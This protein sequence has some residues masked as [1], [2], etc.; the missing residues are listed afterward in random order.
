M[1]RT[2]ITRAMLL[3]DI[4]HNAGKV[5]AVTAAALLDLAGEVGAEQKARQNSIS[6]RLPGPIGSEQEW[7]TLYVVSVAGTL[8]TNWLRRWVK[9]G[10]T[11][12]LAERYEARLTALVGP[13]VHHPTAY[14]KAVPLSVVAEHLK[15]VQSAVRAA[16]TALRRAVRDIA[17]RRAARV[18]TIATKPIDIE[19]ILREAKVLLRKRSRG[20]RA[21]ALKRS[22][23]VCAACNTNNNIVLG[24]RGRRA[25]QVHHHKQLAASD[26]PVVTTVED[27]AVVCA[28]CH[29]L[30]H[31]DP[32]SAIAV[33]DL[34]VLL[35]AEREANRTGVHR[36]NIGMQ[37]ATGA[38][39][40]PSN[41]LAA[42]ADAVR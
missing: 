41:A 3:T 19:N 42:A 27:L 13:V 28:T 15:G 25:L 23:G 26:T 8:Y 9:V 33:E 39:G 6:V 24:G 7:L 40:V 18:G 2:T 31:S 37:P 16:A 12:D 5:A 35:A 20:L 38:D 10:A 11:K 34:R 14:R 21:A 30:I 22:G 17:A 29:A 36:S 1:P 32:K 4:R